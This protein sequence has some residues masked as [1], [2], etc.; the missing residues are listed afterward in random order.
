MIIS[1]ELRN[2]RDLSYPLAV[3][4]VVAS[5]SYDSAGFAKVP[6][7]GEERQNVAAYYGVAAH[8]PYSI[9]G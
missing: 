2:S 5:V 7:I 4:D 1:T 9:V 8:Y 6:V 3:V